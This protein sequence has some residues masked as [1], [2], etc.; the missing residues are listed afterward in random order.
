M[1]YAWG[2]RIWVVVR[3]VGV[4]VERRNAHRIL[5]SKSL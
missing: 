5:V 1:G 4:K 2:R 3:Y